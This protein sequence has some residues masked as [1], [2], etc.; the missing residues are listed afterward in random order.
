MRLEKI[1]TASI[2][3]IIITIFAGCLPTQTII[4]KFEDLKSDFIALESSLQ[5]GE[6][7]KFDWN[8]MTITISASGKQ[9]EPITRN[10]PVAMGSFIVPVTQPVASAQ[11]TDA[12]DKQDIDLKS[13]RMTDTIV[14]LMRRRQS[15]YDAIMNIK[16]NGSVG[17]GNRGLL[18]RP[19]G[20]SGP[21]LDDDGRK[22]VE[23]ENT[24][25]GILFD[26]V[27]RQRGLGS[28]KRDLV[29]EKFAEAQ[30]AMA[31]R[32]FW[33]QDADGTWLQVE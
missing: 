31:A 22:L 21:A 29:G 4:V 28:E 19:T 26:E 7:A 32:G 14:Q 8:T 9:P 20:S 24:D 10:K 3:A 23:A 1:F 33:V 5:A 11:Q 25:R 16:R 30:R 6:W 27:L 12:A 17:E 15:R 2:A 18:A 13:L